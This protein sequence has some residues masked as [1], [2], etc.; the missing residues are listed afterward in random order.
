MK[1]QAAILLLLLLLLAAA[2]AAY[3]FWKPPP[4]GATCA[5][6]ADSVGMTLAAYQKLGI[7]VVQTSDLTDEATPARRALAAMQKNNYGPGSNGQWIEQHYAFLFMPGNYSKLKSIPVGYYTH[8]AGLGATANDVIIPAVCLGDGA[9][10][11]NTFWRLAEN[12]SFVPMTKKDA[13]PDDR[14]ASLGVSAFVDDYVTWAVSQASPLRRCQVPPGK[15]LALATMCPKKSPTDPENP[16]CFASGGFSADNVYGGQ[17]VYASQQQWMAVADKFNAANLTVA[18]WNAVFLGCTNAPVSLAGELGRTLGKDGAG[19]M[20]TSSLPPSP[21]P[22]RASKPFLTAGNGL[23][24]QMVVPTTSVSALDAVTVLPVDFVIASDECS[25]KA[26]LADRKQYIVVASAG[27][28]LVTSAL[29]VKLA[30]TVVLGLGIPTLRLTTPEACVIV[31]GS[32]CC[33]AGLMVEP[34]TL[35]VKALVAWRGSNGRAYDIY[36][37]V[38]GGTLPCASVGCDVQFSVQS[39]ASLLAENVWLWRADHGENDNKA[40]HPSE[41]GGSACNLCPIG[42]HVESGA[43]AYFYGLASEHNMDLNV[44]WE[45]GGSVYFYQSE[46]PY[47]PADAKNFKQPGFQFSGASPFIGRGMGVYSYFPSVTDPAPNIPAAFASEASNLDG[48][49][50]VYLDGGGGF[51]HVYK[52]MGCPVSGSPAACHV[53]PYIAKEWTPNALTCPTCPPPL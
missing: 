44:L 24:L 48:L 9:Q 2:G 42:L 11:L 15:Q 3:F 51:Q 8:V 13:D 29:E 37:R 38:G 7:Y 19:V 28:I 33:L 4:D 16:A 52:G 27:P 49:V 23:Q 26:A 1:A 45:G 50:A 47:C 14:F 10:A 5:A 20:F 22:Q 35:G 39:G 31:S 41:T 21:A 36:T 17:V 32:E 25:L 53:S 6:Y 40:C 34:G 30:G 12:F 18:V 43:T 46:L